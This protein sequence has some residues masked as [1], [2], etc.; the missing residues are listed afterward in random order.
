MN[1]NRRLTA[2]EE[3]AEQVRRQEMRGLIQSWPEYDLTPAELE[4]A[5]DEG[6][7]YLAQLRAWRQAGLSE[8]AVMQRCADEAGMPVEEL[9]AQCRAALETA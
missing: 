3:I 7:R 5:T 1:L 4:E 8:R 6:L 2:L 9:E